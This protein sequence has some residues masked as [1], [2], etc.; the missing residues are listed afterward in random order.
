MEFREWAL[1]QV[2]VP[3]QHPIVIVA[4]SRF[5]HTVAAVVPLDTRARVDPETGLHSTVAPTGFSIA[6]SYR[7]LCPPPAPSVPRW[8]TALTLSQVGDR[9]RGS[10][11][12]RAL[13]TARQLGQQSWAPGLLDP[14]AWPF[15][16][17]FA[18]SEMR[19]Y[20]AAEHVYGGDTGCQV[21]LI[22]WLKVEPD[23][24][25]G[26]WTETPE[27][28]QWRPQACSSLEGDRKPSAGAGLGQFSG[29]QVHGTSG[30]LGLCDQPQIGNS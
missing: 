5:A 2:Q 14:E 25:A 7:P 6:S 19:G 24:N 27:P 28:R 11:T 16:S 4:G 3:S 22:L 1:L 15:T 23:K 17:P 30:G 26:C 20:C 21:P 12:R 29:A 10:E 13:S 8:A 9:G 18:L